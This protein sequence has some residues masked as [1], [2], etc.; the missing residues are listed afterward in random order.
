M[1]SLHLRCICTATA[2]AANAAATAKATAL[3]LH[4]AGTQLE[5]S[6]AAA[7]LPS[8]AALL[9]SLKLSNCSQSSLPGNAKEGSDSPFQEI[10]NC[11]DF[12]F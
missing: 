4:W 6:G 3:L 10:Q 12:D 7:A 5:A 9:P 2:A 11:P 8:Q 1:Q